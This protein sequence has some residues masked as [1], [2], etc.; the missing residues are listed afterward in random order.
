[1][2]VDQESVELLRLAAGTLT[3]SERRVFVAE[4]ALRLCAGNARQAE[5]RFGWG[6]ET[7]RIGLRERETGIVVLGNFQARGRTRTEDSDPKLADDIRAIAEPQTQTD[8]ELKSD[9]R[10]LNLSAREVRMALIEQKGWSVAEAPPERSLRRM[11]NRMNY[12]LKRIQ[13]GKPL[14][15]TPD[16]DAIFENVKAVQSISRGDPET[17]E[18]SVDTKAKVAIGDYSRGGKNPDR[19]RWQTAE[20]V[21][22]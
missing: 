22:P 8:P 3:G 16:T 5:E 14:K 17:L 10:D 2:G 4:V 1:M 19:L 15:K 18:I 20:G 21:G 12:R 13:K 11:L 7:V 9:R 6:R